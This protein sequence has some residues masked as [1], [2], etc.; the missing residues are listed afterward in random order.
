MGQTFAALQSA[1]HDVATA[2][3]MLRQIVMERL[4]VLDCERNAPLS[5]ITTAVTELAEFA[6]DVACTQAFEELDDL[7]GAPCTAEGQRAELWVV[8][9]GQAW[10]A[11]AECVE[12]HRPGVRV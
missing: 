6:L 7:H 3:R 2:L 5:D 10:G 9:H 11:R 4:V 8:G 12:R 1:G